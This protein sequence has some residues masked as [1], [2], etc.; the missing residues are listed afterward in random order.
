M[1]ISRGTAIKATAITGGSLI[2][3][4]LG[5]VI[6]E[7]VSYSNRPIGPTTGTTGSQTG[8]TGSQTGWFGRAATSGAAA[9][10]AS[11]FWEELFA[12]A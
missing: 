12:D 5:F 7:A 6:A 9:G 2:V 1:K 4:V 3:G 8:T 10:T 11:S